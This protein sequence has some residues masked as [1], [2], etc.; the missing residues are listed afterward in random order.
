[1]TRT[2]RPT[3]P[4]CDDLSHSGGKC[5]RLPTPEKGAV[6]RTLHAGHGS[7]AMARTGCLGPS[8][9]ERPPPPYRIEQ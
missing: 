2:T 3:T 7:G 8:T 9:F 5:A 4:L 6:P 1:M